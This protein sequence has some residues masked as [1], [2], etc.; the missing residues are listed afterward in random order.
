MRIS[1]NM[2][3]ALGS[4]KISELQGN[5][6]KTQQQLSTQRRVLTPADDPVAAANILG[7]SQTMSINDQFAANRQNAKNLL[8]QQES[9]LQS[10]TTLLQDV[11]T[12]VINAGNGA[13][14]DSQRQYLAAE[15]RGRFDE[16]MG[17][18]NSRDGAGNFMF[19]GFQI[20]TQPFSEIPGGAKYSGDQGQRM[21]QIGP[22]RHIALNDSGS[23]VFESN[24]TG[25]GDFLAAAASTNTGSGI[26]GSGAVI[27]STLV[28]GHSYSVEFTV[29]PG[30][31]PFDAATTTYVIR[32]TTASPNLYLD[33]ATN[34]WGPAVP[35]TGT[36]YVSGQA[37]TVDGLQFD[38]KGAPANGDKFTLT[39]S[40]NQSIFTTLKDLLNTLSTPGA[41]AA[42]QAKLT[43]GLNVAN[44]NI[45]NALNNVLEVR[46]SVGTRLKEI[47]T[48][49]ST[50]DD[51]KVQ[52][53]EALH[54]LQDID[55]A[56]VVSDFTMQQQ[57][58]EAAQKSFLQISQL[59]LFKFI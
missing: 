36:P 34:T 16:L 56:K 41:G 6:V 31:T 4:T 5:I 21:L 11:K 22:S 48:L 1:T 44:N 50:G 52:Y 40:T 9:V 3:F 39:P 30:A 51:L 10:V 45:D 27:D 55:L 19:G 38:V 25:N 42:G 23:S 13:M 8:S 12:L 7:I 24:R 29:V 32:D 37:I 2:I 18:A 17:L 47:D 59:S 43:N 35:A 20:A 54:Q 14:E 33:P 46:A 49:D 26:A 58:L 15:L 53:T 28:T 57:A